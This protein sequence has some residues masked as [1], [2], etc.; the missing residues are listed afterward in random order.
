MVRFVDRLVFLGG[1]YSQQVA[2]LPPLAFLRSMAEV[3]PDHPV[4]RSM[5]AIYWRGGEESIERVLYRPQYFDKLVAWGGGDAINNVMKYIGPGFQLV[6]FD[7]KTSTRKFSFFLIDAG[8]IKIFPA[9][10][11]VDR[12]SPRGV[13]VE[14]RK[15]SLSL[16]ILNGSHQYGA[17]PLSPMFGSNEQACKPWR[18]IMVRLNL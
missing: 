14:P 6:S 8:A 15:P 12:H 7:P 5:S 2:N 13:Q 18:H 9:E 3:D 11:R 10:P 1:E 16:L 17:S 4:V